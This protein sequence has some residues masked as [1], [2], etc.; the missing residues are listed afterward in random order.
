MSNSQQGGPRQGQPLYQNPV[1]QQPMG[2]QPHMM[3]GQAPHGGTPGG[4][5]QAGGKAKRRVRNFLLQP[6]LQ[7]KIGLFSIL[8]SIL[9]AGALAALLYF[10]FFPLIDTVLKMTDADEEVRDFFMDEWRAKQL[11][12]YLA[13]FV[14]LVAQ[15]SMSI[16]YTHRLV[17]PTYAFRRHI[18]SL[19]EGRYSARTYLRKGDG[20]LEVAD[21]LNHLSEVMDRK[22][23]VGVQQQAQPPQAAPQHI[24]QHEQHGGTGHG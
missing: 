8:L 23:G 19:A 4:P 5:P 2:M 10:N 16:L 15:I 13:F 1:F 24:G 9:F 11:W 7:V 18:R 6:L 17:G 3:Q 22:F 21:E 14:Y 20:F 12:V